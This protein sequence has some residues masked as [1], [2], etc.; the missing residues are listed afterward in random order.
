MATKSN[1]GIML[2]E[3]YWLQPFSFFKRNYHNNSKCF[4]SMIPFARNLAEYC[5]KIDH[6][7]KLTSLL[8]IKNDSENITIAELID[9]FNDIIENLNTPTTYDPNK[10]VVEFILEEAEKIFN[11]TEERLNLENKIV[12]SIAI[13]LLAEIYMKWQINDEEFFD[14]IG[15]NQTRELIKKYKEIFPNNQMQLKL[16]EDV[17][18]ITPESIHLNSFM[19]EPILD[20]SED[21]LKKLY[22]ELKNLNINT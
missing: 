5:W 19:Y 13:R 22:W 17:N 21:Y 9:V 14:T 4:I 18:L 16:L 15:T 1:N 6:K 2:I 10:K 20:M 8:H 3:A 7:N 12:L 11:E